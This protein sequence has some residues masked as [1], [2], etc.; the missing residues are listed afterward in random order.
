MRLV[1]HFKLEWRLIVVF[2]FLNEPATPEIYPLSLHASLPIW[3]GGR[4]R[5]VHESGAGAGSPRRGRPHGSLLSRRGAVRVS[6]GPPAVLF[7]QC[8]GGARHASAQP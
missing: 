6:C 4:H 8:G 3:V 7:A 2:F 1:L 5:G